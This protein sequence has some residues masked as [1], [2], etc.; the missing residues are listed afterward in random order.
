MSTV[1]FPIS[2]PLRRYGYLPCKK[3]SETIMPLLNCC[4][5]FGSGVW[6]WCCYHWHLPSY[7]YF[8]LLSLILIFNRIWCLALSLDVACT[9]LDW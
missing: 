5:Q 3:S 7:Y 6:I 8:R 2:F 4:R 9:R 1:T